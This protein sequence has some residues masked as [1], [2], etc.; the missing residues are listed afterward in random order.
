MSNLLSTVFRTAILDDGAFQ[1]WRERPNLFLRGVLLIVIISLVAGLISF[2]VNLVNQVRPVDVDA[3]E[4]AVRE[5]FEQQLRWNPGYQDPEVREMFEEMIP[6]I[7]SMATD[8][9]RI[10][11]PLPR[12]VTGFFTAVGTWLSQ[13]LAAIGGWL[14][15]GALVLIFVNLLGG[16]AKLPEF[17]GMVSVYA[18]P[19]LLGL[20]TPVPCVGGL[21]ALAGTIW[22]IVV[23]V[24]ATT[25]T[26]GL[27]TGRS[28]VAVVA[29]AFALILLALLFAVLV[30][31]WMVILF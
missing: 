7:I 23:Y 17:L 1:E 4:N 14:F 21:L 9:V 18:V 30:V 22:G 31:V 11:T 6:V 16:S 27:D 20:L 5:S 28:I 13:S 8:L 15:Y 25:V 29:P 24:K 10:E 3:I 2:A 12:G 26:T 19:G